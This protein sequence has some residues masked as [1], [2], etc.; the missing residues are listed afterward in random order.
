[1]PI[2]HGDLAAVQG[3]D[4]GEFHRVV[5]DLHHRLNDFIDAVVVDRR[6]DA[7]REWR[8]W[9]REDPLIHPFLWLRPDLIPP[10]LFFFSLYASSYAWWFWSSC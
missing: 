1:M 3:L 10:A 7:I 6:D 2:T 8:N 5:F 9:I 4:L